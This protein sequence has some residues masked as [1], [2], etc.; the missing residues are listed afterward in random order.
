MLRERAAL[1]GQVRS[2]YDALVAAQR[3][4]A[5]MERFAGDTSG[6]DLV[7]ATQI[8]DALASVR[9][10]LAEAAGSPPDAD[11]DTTGQPA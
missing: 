9:A 10:E 3:A 2:E 7:I 11:D 8:R 1:V 6:Q 5:A 4:S